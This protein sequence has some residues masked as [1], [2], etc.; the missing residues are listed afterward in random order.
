MSEDGSRMPN[1]NGGEGVGNSPGEQPELTAA[2]GT[3]CPPPAWC[4]ACPL[5]PESLK[6][7]RDGFLNTIYG[8]LFD[9]ANT[10]RS[11]APR[12]PVLLTLIIFFLVKLTL[13]LMGYIVIARLLLVRDATPLAQ[14]FLHGPGPLLV[15]GALVFWFGKWFVHS[16]V[17]NLVA[18]LLGGKGRARGVLVVYGLAVIPMAL[19]VPALVFFLLVLPPEFPGLFFSVFAALGVAAWS[20]ALQVVGIREVHGLSTNR[21]ALVI[22]IPAAVMAIIVTICLAMLVSLSVSA[23]RLVEFF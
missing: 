12:P 5:D 6:P 14:W 19:L 7:D 18:E 23:S 10:F 17:L 4:Q 13:S 8:V 2:T 15:L 22:G 20:V 1:S 11:L 21:A 9:P 3:L 16:S